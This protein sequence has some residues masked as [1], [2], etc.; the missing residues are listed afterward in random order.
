MQQAQGAIDAARAAGAPE[1]AKDEFDAAVTALERAHRAADDRDYRQALND[2][3]DARDRAQTSARMSADNMATARVEADRAVAAA[4][5]S[6]D[7]VRKH[8]ADLESGKTPAKALSGPKK[9]IDEAG[10]RLQEARTAFEQKHY[11]VATSTASAVSKA[12]ISAGAELNGI[13]TP[14][15][16][17]GR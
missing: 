7:A 13:T 15:V 1:Y 10:T 11:T 9:A 4:S 5:A 3:L 6:L 8:L 12:I 14:P 17:R 2:A 16:R